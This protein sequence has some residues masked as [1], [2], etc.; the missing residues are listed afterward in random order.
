MPQG[1][2][3]AALGRLLAGG[4]DCVSDPYQ[5]GEEMVV[6]RSTAGAIISI[7]AF[8]QPDVEARKI[9]RAAH[10]GIREEWSATPD[11]ILG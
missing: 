4:A 2:R 8:N 7:N 9:A 11:P 1:C 6:G 10:V 5:L 3:V